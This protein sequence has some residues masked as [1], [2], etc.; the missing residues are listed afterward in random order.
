MGMGGGV[1][2]WKLY[3]EK[4][5]GKINV[6]ARWQGESKKRTVKDVCLGNYRIF[7]SQPVK[8]LEK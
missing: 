8:L 4:K 1:R 2:E 3:T 6:V 5:H 7:D